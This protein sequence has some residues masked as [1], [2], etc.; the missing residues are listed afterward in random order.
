MVGIVNW[1][2]VWACVCGSNKLSKAATDAS[3][4][5][6]LVPLILLICMSRVYVGNH[7]LDQVLMGSLEG[8][9]LLYLIAFAFEKH[10][11]TWYKNISKTDTFGSVLLHPAC[12]FFMGGALISFGLL[13]S[14]EGYVPQLWVDNVEKVCGELDPSKKNPDRASIEIALTGMGFI[15]HPMGALFEQRFLGTHIY[16]RW[17]QVGMGTKVFMFLVSLITLGVSFGSADKAFKI[18]LTPVIGLSQVLLW[19]RFFS[20]FVGN[21]VMTGFL[22]YACFKCGLINTE[23]GKSGAKQSKVRAKAD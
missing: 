9:C 19:K 20:V 14:H 4:F 15:G 1:G 23:T 3:F 8:S 11:R 21:F 12:L 6:I 16:K 5:F 7:T 10:L 17:N 13:R 22:R 2:S 18:V